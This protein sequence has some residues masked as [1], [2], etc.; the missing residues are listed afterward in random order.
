VKAG[1]AARSIVG[2]VTTRSV[3]VAILPAA[4]T[5]SLDDREPPTTRP[6]RRILVT[7]DEPSLRGLLKLMLECDHFEVLE[8]RTGREAVEIA[9]RERPDLLLIDLNMPEMDGYQAIAQ[10][11]LEQAL[12]AMPIV[13]LT[14]QCAAGVKRR[15]LEL[16]A[17]DCIDK[18][19]DADLLLARIHAAMLAA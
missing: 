19:F 17:A 12:N 10:A 18:P 2:G 7:D 11:R 4:A 14:S 13:V 5:R 3:E 15:V 8:A 16:G 9:R 6:C 1:R